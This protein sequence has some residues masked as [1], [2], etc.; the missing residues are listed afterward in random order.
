MEENF[1]EMNRFNV[2]LNYK[3]INEVL[4]L[5]VNDCPLP[6]NVTETVEYGEIDGKLYKIEKGVNW[7]YHVSE[8]E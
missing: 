1:E 2:K 3:Q 8:M 4:F 5:N 7:D 6:I